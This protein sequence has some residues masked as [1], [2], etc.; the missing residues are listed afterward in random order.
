[1]DFTILKIS[2]YLG[3]SVARLFNRGTGRQK[4]MK[5]KQ[6]FIKP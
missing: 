6:L 4:R 3:N 1:M 5:Q 2:G